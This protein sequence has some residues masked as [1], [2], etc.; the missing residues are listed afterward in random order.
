MGEER[1]KNSDTQICIYIFDFSLSFAVFCEILGTF[2][3]FSLEQLFNETI[4]QNW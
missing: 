3:S 4:W 2:T 1:R